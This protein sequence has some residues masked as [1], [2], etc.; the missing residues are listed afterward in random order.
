MKIIILG[1]YG[2]F[3]GRLA[4][5]L[6]DTPDLTMLI[7]GRNLDRATQFCDNFRGVAAVQP[8]QLDRS[9]LD[10]H[11]DRLSPDLVIDASGPFQNYG[12]DGYRVIETCIRF[13]VSYLD[14][15]DAA[16]FVFGI[17]KFDQAAK[18]AGIFVLSGVSSFPILTAAV[19]REISKTM[20]IETVQG[21]IAPSPY[22]GIGL[23]VMRAVLGYAG[24]PV[25]LTR[26]GKRTT[27]HGLTESK[28]CTVAVPGLLPLKNIRFSLVDVPELQVLPPEIP[29]LKDIWMGAGPVPETLHRMLNM[30]AKARAKFNLPSFVPLA[31]IFYKILNL[32]KFGEHR[33]GMFVH[34][35]GRQDGE[36]VE[37][38]W[39]LL[40]EG[41]DGPYIPSMA[42]EAIVRKH[43]K[44]ESP[45]HGARPATQALTLADY[46]V[47]FENRTIY[48]GFRAPPN[49][50]AALYRQILGHAF[51]RLPTQV[52][53]LHDDTAA[54]TWAGIARVQRGAGLLSKA[55]GRLFGF[56]EATNQCPVK[57][58]FEP[59]K[60]G[61][62][63]TRTFG[64]KS[65]SSVQFA[66]T[67]RN[68]KLLVERFGPIN[69]ALALVIDDGKLFLIPRRWSLLGVPL[70]KVFLPSGSSH[71]TQKDGTFHFDVEISAPVIGLIAA[72]QGSLEL[73]A[74]P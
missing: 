30:L 72:Y 51:D 19:L 42:I 28:R 69:V 43:L 11:M 58:Q 46:Q 13:K 73:L 37:R 55:L 64:H 56:P 27:A 33:G 22:A 53:A 49:A 59:H 47:Q 35:T 14:F 41:D 7:C 9:A 29:G 8:A 25:K 39:H 74:Q 34:V 38:S 62:K 71:E 36:P 12:D 20:E 4:E 5:L 48:M 3:G 50:D 45:E 66:G 63:W 18:E 60:G 24:A 31:S 21:G 6:A 23:N 67:G 61:E 26:N 17:S 68:D 65:F 16:E 32:M 70:P 57:V 1:G 54:R 10:Q 2:V 44:A 40:A 52:Q 15:A